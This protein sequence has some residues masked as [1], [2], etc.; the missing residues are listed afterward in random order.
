MIEAIM[1]TNLAD[2][3]RLLLVTDDRLLAGRDLLA[4]CREAP[5]GR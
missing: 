4:V 3:L 5:A 2:A 1:A